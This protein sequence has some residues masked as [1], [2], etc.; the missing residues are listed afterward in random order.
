VT[1][2]LTRR[3]VKGEPLTAADHDENLT[4]LEDAILANA[5]G[6]V[7]G[8]VSKIT[9]G[10]ITI[11]N[12]GEYVTTGLIATL[13]SSSANGMTLGTVDQFGVKNTSGVAKLMDIYG[14]IDAKDGNNLTLGIKLAK[15]G[16]AIDESECRAFTGSGA[17]EAKLMTRWMV[18][19]ANGDEVSL[20]IANHTSTSNLELRR[21]RIVAIEVR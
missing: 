17:Q 12:I 18:S 8:Q 4:K 15:N 10:E 21:G 9:T 3:S 20:L 6:L 11:A 16:I 7:R 1:L 2:N 19:M 14:S 5:A 13:D